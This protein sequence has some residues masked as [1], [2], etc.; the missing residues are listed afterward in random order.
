MPNGKALAARLSQM[1]V[2]ASRGG[3]PHLITGA[4]D[5]AASALRFRV[6]L[7]TPPWLHLQKPRAGIVVGSRA[8]HPARGSSSPLC[9]DPFSTPPLPPSQEMT[10]LGEPNGSDFTGQS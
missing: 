4:S 3:L 6:A 10:D 9:D 2:E 8:G 7:P 5:H 1:G